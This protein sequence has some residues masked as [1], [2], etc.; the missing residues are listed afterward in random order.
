MHRVI[1]STLILALALTSAAHGRQSTQN[2]T[3][4]QAAHWSPEAGLSF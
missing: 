4:A 2:M 3:C 1:F